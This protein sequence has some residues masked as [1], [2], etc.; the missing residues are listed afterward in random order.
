[1]T[2]EEY[3]T[4]AK[5]VVFC[6]SGFWAGIGYWLGYRAAKAKGLRL[7]A[8]AAVREKMQR[9]LDRICDEAF[10]PRAPDKEPPK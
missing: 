4:F 5:I 2:F 3:R 7:L 10:P 1:M 9:E 8:S 6:A